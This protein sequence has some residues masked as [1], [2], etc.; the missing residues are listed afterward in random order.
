[1]V[2]PPESVLERLESI[3]LR[4]QMEVSGAGRQTF[5]RQEA[6]LLVNLG[7][8]LLG[9]IVTGAAPDQ[10]LYGNVGSATQYVGYRLRDRSAGR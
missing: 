5:T 3:Y 6:D 8:D 2:R 9:A 1:M 7:Q 4:T 10:L